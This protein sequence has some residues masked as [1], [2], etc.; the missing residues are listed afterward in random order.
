VSQGTERD[1]DVP[2]E[3]LDEIERDRTERLDPANRPEDAEVDNTGRTFDSGAGMFTD[4]E[5]YDEEN[6]PFVT[7]DGTEPPKPGSHK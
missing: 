1:P 2:Q 5:D 3:T 4:S 7:E 6:R